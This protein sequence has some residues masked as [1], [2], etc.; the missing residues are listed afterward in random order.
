MIDGATGLEGVDL[1]DHEG[2]LLY[3]LEGDPI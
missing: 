2:H 3:A 1:Y